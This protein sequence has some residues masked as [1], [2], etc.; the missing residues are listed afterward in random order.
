M[1]KE[2]VKIKKSEKLTRSEKSELKSFYKKFDT[3]VD[4]AIAIG[5]DRNVLSRVMLK[6]S[7][8]P[9]TIGK[10]RQSI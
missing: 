10:I 1:T 2:I 5:I 4:C 7:G 6:G 3:E 8:S 9:S